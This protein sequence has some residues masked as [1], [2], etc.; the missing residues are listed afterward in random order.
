[1]SRQKLGAV[2][3]LLA[4]FG[5]GAVA[6]GFGTK[7]YLLHRFSERF[8]GPPGRARMGFRLEAMSRALDL[9]AAQRGKIRAIFDEHEDER[10]RVMEKCE[11]EHR[12]LRDRVDAK[13]RDV[14]TAE[15]REKHEKLRRRFGPPPDGPP[16]D[17]PPPDGPP[18]H[19]PP[20][21]G[22]PPGGPPPPP[23]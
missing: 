3:A 16:P 15:Q 18:P 5:L 22:P 9:D 20:P 23:P 1:M 13:V 11:P 4:A 10:R 21:G 6:G 8:G 2:L 12:A 17:G 14:L 19:A 7:S